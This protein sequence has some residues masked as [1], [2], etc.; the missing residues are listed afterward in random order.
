MNADDRNATE[1]LLSDLATRLLRLPYEHG[2]QGL[3]I[4]ALELKR[5]I[6]LWGPRCPRTRSCG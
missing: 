4:R 3:H 2:T 5:R 6:A 1:A